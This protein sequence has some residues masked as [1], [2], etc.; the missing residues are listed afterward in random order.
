MELKNK[1]E[2]FLVLL[3]TLDASLLGNILVGKGAIVKSVSK[4]TK[5]KKQGWKINRFEVV[6]R[7]GYGRKKVKKD[8]IIKTKW[9]C[10]AA[11]SF[12]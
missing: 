7:A 1:E 12:N 3:G 8:N 2:D 4:E 6:I 10:N 5:S 11:S 9:I